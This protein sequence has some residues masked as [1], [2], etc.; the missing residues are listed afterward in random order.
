MNLKVVK[1][2]KSLIRNKYINLKPEELDIQPGDLV[3][4]SDSEQTLEYKFIKWIPEGDIKVAHC[5]LGDINRF[6]YSDS[7][8]LSTKEIKRR[9]LL[10]KKNKVKK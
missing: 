7:V 3:N 1:T 10:K 8:K 9:K 4:H 2:P 6:F 5:R